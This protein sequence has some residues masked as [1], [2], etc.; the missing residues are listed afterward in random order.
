MDESEPCGQDE[1]DGGQAHDTATGD[2]D[3]QGGGETGGVQEVRQDQEV[4]SVRQLH[5]VPR[6]C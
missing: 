3:G 1:G 5:A 6:D 4:G 2:E